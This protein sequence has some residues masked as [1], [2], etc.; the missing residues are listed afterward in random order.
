MIPTVCVPLS[1]VA[2][3]STGFGDG[4]LP[5]AVNIVEACS[6]ARTAVIGLTD[7]AGVANVTVRPFITTG[8]TAWLFEFNAK[9]AVNVVVPLKPS[10]VD[11][12]VSLRSSLGSA[13]K[14]PEP[15]WQPAAF[16][17]PSQPHQLFSTRAVPPVCATPEPVAAVFPTM[18]QR[19]AFIEPLETNRPPPVE[20][21]LPVI[22]HP[23]I[24]VNW[25]GDELIVAMPP[26]LSDEF[27]VTMQFVID[28]GEFDPSTIPPPTPAG[29]AVATLLLTVTPESVVLPTGFALKIPPPVPLS[30]VPCA[31]FPVIEPPV[32]FIV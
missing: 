6:D 23:L 5:G 24:V 20:A 13:S 26:P 30:P 10:V 12:A 32:M 22:V 27:P 14:A 17:N 21:V 28:I 18:R 8:F 25:L 16:G 1:T 7:P 11:P 15:V 19:L 9:L 31:V 3:G 29:P 4:Q 2:E